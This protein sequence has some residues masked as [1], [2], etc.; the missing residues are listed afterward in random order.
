MP[1]IS[2][3]DKLGVCKKLSILLPSLIMDKKSQLN[4]AKESWFEE[5]NSAYL[6]RIVAKHE[7]K[8]CSALFNRLAEEAEK[9][10]TM[11]EGEITKAG[12][13]IPTYRPH[14]RSRIVAKLIQMLGVRRLRSILAAMKI[15]GMSIYLLSEPGHP[16]PK[17]I[18]DVG[19]GHRS[20]GVGNNLR[21]AVFGVNDGLVSNVSLIMGM[22]G[23]Q[24]DHKIIILAGVAGLLAGAFSMGAG[25][26]VSVRS[27]REM[28]E[29]QIDLERKELELYPNEEAAEL[30]LIYHARGLSKEEA[31]KVAQTLMSDPDNAL[32]TL[33]REELGLNPDDLVSPYSAALFSFV[34]FI[35]GAAIPLLPFIFSRH[36]SVVGISI[37]ITALCLFVIGGILSLYTGRSALKSGLRMLAIGAGAGLITYLIGNLLGVSLG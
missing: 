15:R 9:Q 29:H 2:S 32:D 14:L 23:A 35:I 4:I 18:A 33:T 10:A 27:Q 16:M 17:T 12:G 7:S 25:E 34:S 24:A 1:V 28:F 26:Y 36:V 13:T 31:K 8:Q 21:A 20:M 6:Y 3:L 11:W 22:V 19:R 37:G 30:A 5:K